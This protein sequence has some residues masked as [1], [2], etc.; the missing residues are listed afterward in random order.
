MN[1]K[2]YFWLAEASKNIFLAYPQT[3]FKSNFFDLYLIINTYKLGY[4]VSLLLF[5]SV[6]PF[7]MTIKFK[8]NERTLAPGQY[9][10]CIA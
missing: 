3:A 5:Y 6:I 1:I 9:Q 2:I 7:Y 10:R 4:M 8:T